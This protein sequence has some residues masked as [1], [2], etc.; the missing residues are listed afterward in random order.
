M[1]IERGGTIGAA[2]V[3]RAKPDG[4]TLLFGDTSCQIIAPYLMLRP[5]YD[6][7]KDFTPISMIATSSTA[8]VVHPSVPATNLAEFV[9]YAKEH[10]D[11]LSYGSAGT[12]TVTHL[13]GEL[14]K[15][16]IGAPK[17]L[18][19]PYRGAGPGLIDLV[20]GVLPMMTPNVTSQV[21]AFHRAGKVRILAVCAPQRLKAA[22]EIPAATESLPGMVVQLTCGVLGPA[23]LPQPVVDQIAGITAKVVQDPGFNQA[24]GAAGLEARSDASPTGA[25]EFLVAERKHLLPIIAAAGLKPQ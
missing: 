3:A 1:T 24:L 13:A 9:K 17:I 12:G 8:I 7:T 25:R 10:Q 23:G 5:P 16:L 21:L 2:T 6:P 4:Y 19:V 18:H 20:A 15:Q 11:K 22:P 14:F